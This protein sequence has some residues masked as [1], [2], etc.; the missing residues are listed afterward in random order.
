MTIKII[1]KSYIFLFNN[2]YYDEEAGLLKIINEKSES[3]I[4]FDYI[5]MKNFLEEIMNEKYYILYYF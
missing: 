4:V 5:E 1:T 2:V 3:C